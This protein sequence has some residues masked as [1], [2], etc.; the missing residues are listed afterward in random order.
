MEII[1]RGILTDKNYFYR[2][3]TQKTSKERQQSI[4]AK[5]PEVKENV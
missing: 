4:L 1:I 2:G 3:L 5:I